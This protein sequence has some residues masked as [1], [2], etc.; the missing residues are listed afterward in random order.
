MFTSLADIH[1][2]E[3]DDLLQQLL[4]DSFAT[5]QKAQADLLNMLPNLN[6][7]QL[8]SLRMATEGVSLEQTRRVERVLSQWSTSFKPVRD[9]LN[10]VRAHVTNVKQDPIF[11]DMFIS[12]VTLDGVDGVLFSNNVAETAIFGKIQE[13]YTAVE[14][15]AKGVNL[16]K[17]KEAL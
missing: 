3:V 15:A 11:N 7:E 5:R 1:A 8:G 2:D 16:R 17:L 14:Q 13:K 4:S 10:S 6:G 12:N 9:L